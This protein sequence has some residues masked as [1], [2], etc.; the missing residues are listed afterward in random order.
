MLRLPARRHRRVLSGAAAWAGTERWAW[1]DHSLDRHVAQ[2]AGLFA[3]GARTSVPRPLIERRW[4]MRPS[5]ATH[6]R[7]PQIPRFS[8]LRFPASPNLG[9]WHRSCRFGACHIGGLGQGVPLPAT[10]GPGRGHFGCFSSGG[11]D[12]RREF[13]SSQTSP[14][15]HGRT[16]ISCPRFVIY[17][18]ARK[19]GMAWASR[20]PTRES[21]GPG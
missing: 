17:S 6:P 3:P 1:N 9:V 4:S 12:P 10:R 18:R 15:R 11:D 2:V 16:E 13:P 20:G 21:S 5:S 8:A 7:L 19:K 14:S